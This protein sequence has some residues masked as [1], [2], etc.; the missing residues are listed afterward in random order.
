VVGSS[1]GVVV[2]SGAVGQW[3][4]AGR[5][6]SPA[7]TDTAAGAAAA[8]CSSCAVGWCGGQYTRQLLLSKVCPPCQQLALRF[9]AAPA[10]LPRCC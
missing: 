8:A 4:G 2:S 10:A 5:C 9:T 7:A 3:Q 1:G 6:V